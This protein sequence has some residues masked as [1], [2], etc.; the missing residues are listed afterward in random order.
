LEDDQS[1]LK[2]LCYLII[3]IEDTVLL[4][5]CKTIE[6][7]NEV[8]N[9]F[10]NLIYNTEEINALNDY[11]I[12]NNLSFGGAADLLIVSVFIQNIYKSFILNLFY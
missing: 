11:C 12:S 1:K 5:R 3:N 8:I 10:K 6:K 7:Y 9:K 2:A 4:K